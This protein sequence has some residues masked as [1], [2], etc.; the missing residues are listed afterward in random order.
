MTQHQIE[1]EKRFQEA[2]SSAL[3]VLEQAVDYL[4]GK[5]E[6][7]PCEYDPDA[8][9]LLRD[10]LGGVEMWGFSNNKEQWRALV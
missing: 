3:D 1:K 7:F 2:R 4:E 10:I 9:K 5:E 6:G 8:C